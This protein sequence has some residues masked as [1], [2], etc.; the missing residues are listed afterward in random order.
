M[1]ELLALKGAR[2]VLRRGGDGNVSSL[3]GG[4]LAAPL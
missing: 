4:E 1:L 3:S 2:A